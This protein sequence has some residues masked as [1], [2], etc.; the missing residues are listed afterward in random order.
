MLL[1]YNH[2]RLEER[3]AE[4]YEDSFPGNASALSQI[5]DTN[6]EDTTVIFE[7]LH[8]FVIDDDG[9]IEDK[10]IDTHELCE[11]N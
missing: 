8:S 10:Y 7:K 6:P 5:P 4:A 3:E 9:F 11:E 1:S 2:H